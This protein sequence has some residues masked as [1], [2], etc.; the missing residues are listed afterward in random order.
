[1]HAGCFR[2]KD[3]GAAHTSQVPI[4]K[5]VLVLFSEIFHL[6]HRYRYQFVEEIMADM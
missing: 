3:N 1:M 5:V 6:T 2:S 4:S